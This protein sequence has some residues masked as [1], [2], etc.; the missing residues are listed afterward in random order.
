MSF[1]EANSTGYGAHEA[2]ATNWFGTDEFGFTMM[3]SAWRASGAG[4]ETTVSQLIF[5]VDSSDGDR[6]GIVLSPRVRCKV[7]FFDP[8]QG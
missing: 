4:K 1:T 5:D 3:P 7:E 6:A 2:V 8:L